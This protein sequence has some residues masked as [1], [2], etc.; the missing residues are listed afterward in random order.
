MKKDSVLLYNSFYNA[1]KDLSLEEKGLLLD[2]VFLYNISGATPELPPV[3]RMAFNFMRDQ[4]DRDSAKYE[5]RVE[6]NR[7]NGLKG[8]RPT[9]PEKAKKPSGLNG[10]P[11]NPDEPKK[12]DTDTEDDTDSLLKDIVEY[13]NLKTGKNFRVT[14]YSTRKHIQARLNDGFVYA[15][16]KRVIDIKCQ[17]WL[18]TE[19]D[20]YLRPET[21]FGSKFESY[22]NEKPI[23]GNGKYNLKPG[24]ILIPENNMRKQKILENAGF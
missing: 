3:V 1:I 18:N 22:L 12:P 10:N 13:L 14:T 7:Q 15:D 24:Q 20:K 23:N 2:A 21:L 6:A 19:N 9:N 17:I 16:F 11:K 8:G 4:F 5:K